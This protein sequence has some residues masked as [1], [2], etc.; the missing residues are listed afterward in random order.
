[1][2]ESILLP[3]NSAMGV[4]AAVEHAIELASEMDATLHILYVTQRGADQYRSSHAASADESSGDTKQ[5]HDAIIARAE[6]ADIG[7]EKHVEPGQLHQTTIEFSREH[8]VDLIVVPAENKTGIHHILTDSLAEKAVREPTPPVLAV[9][10][11][12]ETIRDQDVYECLNCGNSFQTT[13]DSVE[14][15][16]CPFCGANDVED[17]TIG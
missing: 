17:R 16:Q 13:V 2:Y 9:S 8:N 12:R 6:D 7:I 10:V 1:M 5:V 14:N 11:A 3:T 15:V 4:N